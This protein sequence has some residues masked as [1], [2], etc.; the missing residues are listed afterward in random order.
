MSGWFSGI[1]GGNDRPAGIGGRVAARPGVN[2]SNQTQD[3]GQ[4]GG[5]QPCQPCNG[6]GRIRNPQN[7]QQPCPYCGGQGAR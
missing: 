5:P 7:Q 4:Q 6:S 1:F 3:A 2:Q